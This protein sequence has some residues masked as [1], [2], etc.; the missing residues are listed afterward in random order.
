M[1]GWPDVVGDRSTAA[2]RA[3][4]VSG[5]DGGVRGMSSL[6]IG[7]LAATQALLAIMTTRLPAQAPCI[8][9]LGGNRS[10]HFGTM[11]GT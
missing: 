1:G 9:T 2:A 6:I 3:D 7:S 8:M 11:R 4:S 10:I 5:S